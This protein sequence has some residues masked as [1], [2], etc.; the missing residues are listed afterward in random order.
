MLDARGQ[1]VTEGTKIMHNT[2]WPRTHNHTPDELDAEICRLC[3][4]DR[5]QHLTTNNIA[6]ILG[7][8]LEVIE[9]RCLALGKARRLLPVGLVGG[10]MNWETIT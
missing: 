8:P 1:S 7:H 6:N 5:P 2:L 4:G 3:E 10:Q 9:E